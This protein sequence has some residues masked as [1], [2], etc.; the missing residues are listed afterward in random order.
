MDNPNV[1]IMLWREDAIVLWDWISKVDMERLPA[2]D[3]AVKQALTDLL[4]RLEQSV[5]GE[6]SE[7][8]VER[9][10]REV[11]KDMGW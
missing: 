7:D 10:R 8:R 4:T 3:P 6:L 1:E 5:P 9:A 2:D 11:A